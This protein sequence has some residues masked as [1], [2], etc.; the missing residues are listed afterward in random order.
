MIQD[1]LL[2]KS[3][4]G[5]L[6]RS[7]RQQDY[8]KVLNTFV[9]VGILPQL[10]NLNNQ[11]VYGRRGTGKTHIFRVLQARLMEDT[12][13]TV[14]YIDAR[15]LGSTSQFSDPEVAM[16]QRCI[17]LFRDI[18]GEIYSALLEF[19]VNKPS[20]T[21]EAALQS[22]D[23]LSRVATEPVKQYA[24]ELITTRNADKSTDGGTL[25]ITLSKGSPSLTAT[26]KIDI[27]SE[28]ERT[29]SYRVAHDDKVIFPELHAILSNTVNKAQTTLYILFDEWSSIPFDVQP[30]LAEFLKRGFLSEPNVVIKIAALEYRS[31]FGVRNDTDILGFELGSD[32]ST[33]LDIDDYYVYDRSPESVTRNFADMLFKHLRS[34]LPDNFLEEQYKVRNGQDLASRMFT[35]KLIFEELVRASEGVARD[36][37]NIFSTAFFDAQRRTRT[38]IDQKAILESARQWFEKDKSQ[39]LD[40]V[41][42]KVLRRIVDNVIGTRR[43]RSFLLPRELERHPVIQKLFDSR[44]IHLM[45]RGYA[46]KDNP[47]VRY[48]IYTLDYGT[49]V[50]LMNTSKQPQIEFI[51]FIEGDKDLVVPFNDKRSIRRIILTEDY[52]N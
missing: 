35:S 44:V 39:N 5:I 48:N 33:A 45:H 8:K 29:T 36:L 18:L 52:L 24:E 47:G 22:L 25:G 46:D 21:A 31:N 27:T 40:D 1:K 37:I 42:Q 7:E 3:V 12:K 11:I 23:E 50:D 9:D 43:A 14:V 16:K 20:E 6:Q 41:L 51:E 15:T 19:I 2:M 28:N 30:Y 13:N 10:D 34:E 4:S 38:S 26:G 17:S 49:Y 32:I